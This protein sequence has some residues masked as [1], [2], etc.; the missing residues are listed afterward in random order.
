MLEE[1]DK[2]L[3][4]RSAPTMDA[5]KY[6]FIEFGGEHFIKYNIININDL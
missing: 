1:V 5:K 4:K 2:V 3:V 6:D